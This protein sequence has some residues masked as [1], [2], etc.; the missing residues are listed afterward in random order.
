MLRVWLVG[1]KSFANA[2]ME[3]LMSRRDVELCGVIAPEGDRLHRNAEIHNVVHGRVPSPELIRADDTDLIL[4]AHGHAFISAETREAARL[5]AIGYHPSLLPR[6]R[7]RSAI[8]WTIACHDPIAGGTVYRLD[9]GYDTGPIVLQDWCHV[10]W[11]WNASDL[12]R[13]R[14]F[15][16]G[17]RLLGEVVSRAAAGDELVGHIQDER[18]ATSEPPWE[19]LQ[20]HL[21]LAKQAMVERRGR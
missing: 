10:D 20:N 8:E 6:H 9:D 1:Q 17:L 16:M 14:L 19:T 7:G 13:E 18:F 11:R 2:V 21:N 3:D 5:G 4:N 12:W 15:R